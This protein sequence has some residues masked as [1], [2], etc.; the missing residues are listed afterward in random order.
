MISMKYMLVY[1]ALFVFAFDLHSL[2][3]SNDSRYNVF[4]T[5]KTTE[6]LSWKDFQAKP[7]KRAEEAAMTTSSVEFSYYIKNQKISWI[8]SAKFFPKL[9]WSKKDK[10]LDFILLHEQRHFDITELYARML[11]KEFSENIHSVK[12]VA[13][14]EKIGQRILKYWKEE[15]YDYDRETNH[16][17]NKVKQQ[18]WNASILERMDALKEFSSI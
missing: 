16:S 10:Q 4:Y 8:V 2:P 7:V 15:Q 17:Q 6:P 1:I 14:L 5:W 12:D 18:E 11:R 9:S 3:P 13:L